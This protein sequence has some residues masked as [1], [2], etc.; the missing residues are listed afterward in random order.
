MYIIWIEI[1]V[2]VLGKNP[3]N[4]PFAIAFSRYSFRG[5]AAVAPA[6][7]I[8]LFGIVLVLYIRFFCLL[9]DSVFIDYGLFGQCVS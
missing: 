1:G 6:L 4:V 8:V 9:F 7:R 3:N 5:V 2:R